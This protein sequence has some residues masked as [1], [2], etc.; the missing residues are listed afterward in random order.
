[1]IILPKLSSQKIILLDSP[2]Y[3]ICSRAVRKA[4]LCGIDRE[5]VLVMN[6]GAHGLQS[7]Y[8]KADTLTG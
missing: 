7:D 2:Y 4:F 1:M 3:H 6:I 8:L 5:S